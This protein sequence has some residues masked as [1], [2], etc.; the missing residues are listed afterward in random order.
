[1]VSRRHSGVQNS[2]IDFASI[3]NIWSCIL[4]TLQF[5]R[6]FQCLWHDRVLLFEAS[7]P[8]VRSGW[9][10]G[11]GKPVTAA[12]EWLLKEGPRVKMYVWNVRPRVHVEHDDK[13]INEKQDPKI[14]KKI[15]LIRQVRTFWTKFA[16]S[17]VAVNKLGLYS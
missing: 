12:A 10:D 17:V 1:M 14:H 3:W 16:S 7:Y 15:A 6:V 2:T 8:F 9:Y 5:I 13:E 4:L 11:Y